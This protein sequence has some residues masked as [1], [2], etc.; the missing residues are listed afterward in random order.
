MK[1]DDGLLV[2]FGFRFL[3]PGVWSR[4]SDGALL[5]VDRRRITIGGVV[6]SCKSRGDLVRLASIKESDGGQG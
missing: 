2:K 3:G 4:D 6:E 5:E 1:I